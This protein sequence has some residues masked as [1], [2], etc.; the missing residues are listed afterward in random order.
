M[1]DSNEHRFLLYQLKLTID[2]KYVARPTYK[3]NSSVIAFAESAAI[4]DWVSCDGSKLTSRQMKV[5]R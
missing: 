5:Y 2:I 3:S 4:K 1:I